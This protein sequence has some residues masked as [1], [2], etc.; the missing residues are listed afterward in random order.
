MGPWMHLQKLSALAVGS[1]GGVVLY[2]YATQDERRRFVAASW[3]TISKPSKCAVW[4]YNW[5]RREPTS[6]VEPLRHHPT[7]D[8]ESKYRASLE[9]AK[10]KA[11]RHIILVRH[12]EY[13]DKILDKDSSSS[14]TAQQPVSDLGL[15]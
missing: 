10:S 14:S 1:A 3:T 2:M 11:T 13:L 15:P 8:D 12:G 7:P 4:D 6:L 5:D 9:K